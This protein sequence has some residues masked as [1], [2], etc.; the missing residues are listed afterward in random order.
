MSV[1]HTDVAVGER[2]TFE[3]GKFILEDVN[4]SNCKYSGV[5][6]KSIILYVVFFRKVL[7]SSLYIT[8]L[9]LMETRIQVLSVMKN[10]E[11]VNMRQNIIHCHDR[12]GVVNWS[13]E[14]NKVKP[15]M[16]KR[17][18]MPCDSCRVDR[19]SRVSFKGKITIDLKEGS[20]WQSTSAA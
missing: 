6:D 12:H 17:C 2:T 19:T 5:L 4:A 8:T 3:K 16:V 14:A 15:C 9:D 1:P 13:S 11:Y 20:V 7:G 18:L 10:G